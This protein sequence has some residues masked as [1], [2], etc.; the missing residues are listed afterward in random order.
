LTASQIVFKAFVVCYPVD[1]GVLDQVEFDR[2]E[3]NY[4]ETRAALFTSDVIALLTLGVD[5]N[6]FAA[7]G[8]N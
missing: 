8:A 6:F 4:L 5:V 3:S 1:V 7:F 2:V